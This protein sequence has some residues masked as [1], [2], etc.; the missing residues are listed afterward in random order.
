MTRKD[1]PQ[2]ILDQIARGVVIPACPLALTNSRKFDERRQRA[3]MRYYI[4]AGAG[5]VAVGM[6]FTQFEIRKPG[7]DLFEPV[8]RVCSEEID[9]YS[10]QVGRPI[11][12]VA[13]INGLTDSALKQA[14]LARDLGYHVSIVS[15]AA[16]G[17]AME[18]E[19]IH[20]IRELAKVMPLFGFYLLTG[21]G[22]IKLP[23]AFWRDLV[24]VENVV[25]I[26]IA[27]FDRY[28]TIDVVRALA[29]S[30]REKDV[31]LYTGND[32]SIIYDFVTPYRFGS[33]E[34]ARTVRI[35]GG[36][37]GQWGCWTK[38]AVELH[39]RLLGIVDNDD[40][41]TP[42]LLT[43][44]AQITDANAALFDPS[45]GY[46]GSIPG[47]NE[48][49]RRQGLLEGIWTLKREEVLSPGQAEEI[50]RVY[51]A[52]PHLN[53]DDFVKANLDRWLA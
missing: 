25:G 44:S 35:R 7:V 42:E 9:R 33:A 15:M 34:T 4:D 45:H 37:L 16:F 10:A 32:D 46:A 50:D 5:G 36:L 26:K 1:L 19:L 17:A 20:H 8:L 31:T 40:P 43:L 41:V 39:E 2:D 13:G 38:R 6:H 12:K 51:A 30:G 18:Q 28:G 49:L 47:V 23:Y 11:V 3:L 48:V 24:E 53:D 27:P 22:G 52:Y 29:D 21:V 14:E